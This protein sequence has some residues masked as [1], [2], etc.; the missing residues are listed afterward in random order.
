MP[1]LSASQYTAQARSLSCGSTGA[2]GPTGPVGPVGPSGIA[3]GRIYYFVISTAAGLTDLGNGPQDPTYDAYSMSPQPGP[4]PAAN[5]PGNP[6]TAYGDAYNGFFTEVL[7]SPSTTDTYVQIGKFK[8]LPG[9]PGTSVINPGVWN[10]STNMYSFIQAGATTDITT[11]PTSQR[12]TLAYAEVYILNG[13]VQ[14][15]GSAPVGGLI[16]TSVDRPTYV[17]GLINDNIQIPVVIPSNV[18]IS[19]PATAQI[20]VVFKMKG[21]GDGKVQQFWTEGDSI[22]QV[23]TTIAAQ[24]GPT[25]PTGFT[26]STGMTGP[27]GVTGS[28]GPSGINGLPGP[29]GP[30][31]PVGPIGPTPVIANTLAYQSTAYNNNDKGALASWDNQTYAMVGYANGAAPS[32]NTFVSESYSWLGGT[33]GITFLQTGLYALQ[34]N[35]TASNNAVFCIGNNVS[36]PKKL[37]QVIDANYLPGQSPLILLP[38][39]AGLTGSDL[40]RIQFFNQSNGSGITLSGL[41]LNIWKVL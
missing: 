13:G 15:N 14:I 19:T 26:G 32:S 25:G 23:V 27:T 2:Q 30:I 35:W 36:T 1:F 11:I 7:G 31:G 18:T 33:Q 3:T 39:V 40:F 17:T 37:L 12:P 9:D 5:A 16:A 22:S 34:F 24:S 20:Q 21:L 10:F 8:T 38:F 6:N 4:T 41:Q 29:Q 28:T